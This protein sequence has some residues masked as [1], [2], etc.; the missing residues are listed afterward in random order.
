MSMSPSE[1]ST[2]L[3]REDFVILPPGSQDARQ[4]LCSL[5]LTAIWMEQ[6]QY[7]QQAGLESKVCIRTKHI[8]SFLLLLKKN[9]VNT[10]TFM[11][12]RGRVILSAGFKMQA[13]FIEL[14]RQKILLM[15]C[16]PS[17]REQHA[18]HKCYM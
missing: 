16:L 6:A 10:D 4:K 7:W 18:S 12:R 8:H 17:R 2:V 13:H 3:C 5:N 9:K 14:L 11:E 15:K 1:Q